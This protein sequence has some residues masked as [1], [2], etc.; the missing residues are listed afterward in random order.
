LSTVTPEARNQSI[1]VGCHVL[2]DLDD[3]HAVVVATLVEPVEEALRAIVAEREALGRHVLDRTRPVLADVPIAGDVEEV[4]DADLDTGAG[5]AGGVPLVGVGEPDLGARRGPE[6]G[7]G[8]H[9]F[10]EQRSTADDRR[11]VERCRPDV[12]GCVREPCV[13]AGLER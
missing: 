12:D 13:A 4:D 11:R 1:G 3:R 5:E 7:D 9:P 8:A 10:G 6:L 2:D